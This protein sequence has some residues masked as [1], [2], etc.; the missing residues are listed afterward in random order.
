MSKL[1]KK[2]NKIYIPRIILAMEILDAPS[3]KVQFLTNEDI[4][5]IILP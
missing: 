5:T 3:V 2:R 4:S 1:K